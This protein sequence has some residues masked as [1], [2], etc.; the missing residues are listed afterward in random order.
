VEFHHKKYK[1]LLILCVEQDTEM[2]EAGYLTLDHKGGIFYAKMD[3]LIPRFTRDEQIIQSE[4][5]K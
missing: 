5:I 4:V 1:M 2:W 3:E